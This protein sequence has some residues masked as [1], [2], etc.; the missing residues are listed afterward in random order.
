MKK[1]TEARELA[2]KALYQ[3]DVLGKGSAEDVA[4]FV[5]SHGR[6]ELWEFAVELARGCLK[7]QEELDS[8]ISETSENWELARMP[9]ID[10]NILRIGAY[11]LMFRKGTPPRVAINEA[12]E[13]A[14]RY[15]SETSANF[16]NGVLDRIYEIVREE[17]DKDESEDADEG[18]D[19][20][21]CDGEGNCPAGGCEGDSHRAKPDPEA[22]AD[23][24]IHSNASDG[25]EK[26]ADLVKRAAKLGLA[27][28]AL[29]DH[30]SLQGIEEACRTAEEVGIE[31]I[32]G[33]ELTA[34]VPAENRDGQV[35]VH[36]LGLFVDP[37]A[38]RLTA[39]LER[40]RR[41][42]VERVKKISRKLRECGFD[43][44]AK[45]ILER[46]MDG[47]VGRQHVAQEMVDRGICDNL[48]EAFNKYI[49]MDGPAYVPKEELTPRQ[50]IDLIDEAGGVSVFAHP[51]VSEESP[52]L[53]REM[54]DEGL[55]GV[56]VHYPTHSA[57]QKKQYMDL[58]EE[59]DLVVSGGS[60]FHGES[61][62]EIEIG[63]E[64]VSM[65]DVERLRERC[66]IDHLT[67]C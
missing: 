24:H 43:I 22:R 8:T 29:T 1:R 11:E 17:E 45:D 5:W 32:P 60:D 7:R 67:S 54:V 36:V 34:Y 6:R 15:G 58:A 21:G 26:P 18:E 16:V 50:A 30:D 55:D 59:L 62:P 49:G 25:S 66:H 23:L 47:A 51:G 9:V 39:E 65:V 13:L 63:Q 35:E 38:E 41:I 57:S 53:I 2:L 64:T 10:R 42:R 27:A 12:I 4:E 44:E 37:H 48:R 28:I 46:A 40:L 33:V 20:D 31:L 19:P 52:R 56:E 61:K 3:Y 14:K